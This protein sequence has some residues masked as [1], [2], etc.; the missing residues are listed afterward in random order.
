MDKLSSLIKGNLNS[1]TLKRRIRKVYS[2]FL[3]LFMV[4]SSSDYSVFNDFFKSVKALD[5]SDV[6]ITSI[7][8]DSEPTIQA[9]GEIQYT[10]EL[11]EPI[12]EFT[13]ATISF[14]ISNEG[15]TYGKWLS[16]NVINNGTT[17]IMK[18]KAPIY[19][20]NGDWSI[21]SITLEGVSSSIYFMFTTNPQK[22][23]DFNITTG[24]FSVTGAII[25]TQPPVLISTTMVK[26]QATIR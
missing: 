25:D 1:T 20:F 7:T 19:N 3:V 11:S 21:S 16:F 17:L 6:S 10:I 13:Y 23:S 24:N 5:Y 12:Y 8:L 26:N 9:G 22:P 15:L 18:S 2:L 14:N 4:V